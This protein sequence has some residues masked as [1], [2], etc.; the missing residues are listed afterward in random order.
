MS[1]KKN[2]FVTTSHTNGS[3]SF[4]AGAVIRDMPATQ[5][6]DLESVGLVRE[7]TKEEVAAAKKEGELPTADALLPTAGADETAPE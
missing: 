2:A 6:A 4:V 1:D 5:L 7:A 3:I